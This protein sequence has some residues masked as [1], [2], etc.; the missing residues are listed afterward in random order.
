ML[1]RRRELAIAAWTDDACGGKGLLGGPGGA[2]PRSGL[3]RRSSRLR[4]SGCPRALESGSH[5]RTCGP[6][7]RPCGRRNL[8]RF[9]SECSVPD[10]PR[11]GRTP[12]VIRNTFQPKRSSRAHGTR[13]DIPISPCPA[14][15][16]FLGRQRSQTLRPSAVVNGT[17]FG[18]VFGLL[19]KVISHLRR[20][21][22][23]NIGSVQRALTN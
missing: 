17:A 9:P 22:V 5:T 6:H 10:G 8:D 12:P 2:R 7:A 19:A 4:P 14:F 16:F 13:A 1:C 20:S 11:E 3:P 15:V 18:S 23:A 21:D